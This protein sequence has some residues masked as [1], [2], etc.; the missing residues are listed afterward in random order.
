MNDIN[1]SRRQML[2]ALPTLAV[3]PTL[4]AQSTA[5]P[6]LAAK[7][8]NHFM[9]S[10]SDVQR[11]VDF[12]QGLFGMPIQARHESTVL[13]RVGNGPQ[14]IGLTPAGSNPPSI[15]HFGLAVDN[16]DVDRV[17]H[18]L[19]AQGVTKA[20]ASDPGLAGGPMKV[21]QTMRGN[22]PEIFLG[23]PDGLVVQIQDAS[24]CGGT[25]AKGGVC[26]KVEPSS[27]KGVLA[28]KD[29]NHA[30]I[31]VG[32]SVRTV[33]FYQSLFGIHVQ[34]HQAPAGSDAAPFY[35]IGNSKQ[36][37]MFLGGPRRDG[38]AAAPRPARIDHICMSMD[39]FNPETVTKVLNSY[40]IKSQAQGESR[41]PM[42]T[43]TTLR[44]PNRGGAESGTP[45]LY[46]V[47]PDGLSIQL[48]DSK[49][50]GGSG[51]LGDACSV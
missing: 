13:L 30:T 49:Y 20:A 34:G 43:Y 48:Q 16:F 22:T 39:G 3:A 29:M 8:F 14:F 38:A 31:Q 28:V 41:G 25:G 44:M 46:F 18:A 12:Y 42:M 37:V 4:W 6:P 2:L 50:C 10:V 24:Y 11:S 36:F 23:D 51:F 40:G 7:Y 5:K 47:D 1:F 19:T 21:R 9:L 45:E 33:E 35:G 17:V 15:S 27:K 26:N 32:D